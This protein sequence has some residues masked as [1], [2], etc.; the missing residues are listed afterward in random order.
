MI[1]FGLRLLAASSLSS[2]NDIAAPAASDTPGI[3]P[4]SADLAF[5]LWIPSIASFDTLGAGHSPLRQ[6]NQRAGIK[7][8]KNAADTKALA[9]ASESVKPAPKHKH[10]I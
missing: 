9:L 3:V 4:R 1:W 7:Q 6:E 8:L 2:H 10:Y 5:L